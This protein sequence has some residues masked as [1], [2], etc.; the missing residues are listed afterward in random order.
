[1]AAE[2]LGCRRDSWLLSLE[3]YRLG[4]SVVNCQF[5]SYGRLIDALRRGSWSR[6]MA[7]ARAART[8][9]GRSESRS[10]SSRRVA[11]G[12]RAHRPDATTPGW[13]AEALKACAAAAGGRAGGPGRTSCQVTG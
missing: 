9:S 1:M 8:P 12:G 7:Y 13:S 11:A 3:Q 10:W 2:D 5:V 4:H 6:R